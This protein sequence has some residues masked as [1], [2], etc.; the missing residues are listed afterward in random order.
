[1]RDLI[2]RDQERL[3]EDRFKTLIG[4]GV[5]QDTLAVNRPKHSEPK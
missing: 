4:E 2:R 5:A 1:M 3:A